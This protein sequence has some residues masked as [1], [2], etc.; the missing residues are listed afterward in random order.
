M[1]A[2]SLRSLMLVSIVASLVIPHWPAAILSAEAAEAAPST[3]D[4]PATVVEEL[5][6]FR[7]EIDEQGQ[8]I[9]RLYRA[10]GP[11][12]KE[13]EAYAAQLKKQDEEDRLLAMDRIADAL[14]Q[15]L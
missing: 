9:E 10:L 12:L 2:Y 5:R 14:D 13:L 6:R 15:G 11:R 3:N 7:E 4:L 8:R 1:N